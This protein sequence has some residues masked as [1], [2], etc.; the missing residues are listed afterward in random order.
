MCLLAPLLCDLVFS[1]GETALFLREV[2]EQFRSAHVNSLIVKRPGASF[3]E[4][5]PALGAPTV[6]IL[7]I[8]FFPPLQFA[9]I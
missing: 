9:A 1:S 3:L 8:R 2:R 5:L 6:T 4:Q 7:Y